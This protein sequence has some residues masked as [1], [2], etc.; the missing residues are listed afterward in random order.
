MTTTIA[1]PRLPLGDPHDCTDAND[2]LTLYQ[3]FYDTLIRRT[4]TGYVPHLAETWSVEPDARTWTFIIRPGVRFHDGSPCDAAVVAAS[5]ERMAREDKGYTLGSPAVWRQYLGGARLHAEGQI[6]TVHLSRPMADLL[7]V[8]VQGFIVAPSAFPRL[9]AGDRTAICGT[10][11]YI[12]ESIGEGEVIARRNPDWFGTPA[13]NATL[14][15]R[16][17]ADPVRR[18]AMVADGRAALANSIPQ[19]LV[20][21]GPPAGVQFKRF[22]IPVC[23]IYLLNAAKGP[24]ADA[25]VRRALSLAIDRTRIIREVVPDAATPLAGFVSPLH[26]GAGRSPVEGPDLATAKALLAEAGHADGLTLAVD[27]PTRLPDEAERLTAILGSEL[28]PLGVRLDVHYHR[29]REAYAHMVRRKEIRDLCV[30]DSSP[31]STFRILYEK[32]DS[33]VAGAWW[34]GYRNPAVERLIDAA[35]TETDDRRR[36][37]ILEE[38]YAELQRDPPWLTLYNPI[39]TIALR[40]AHPGFVMPVDGVIDPATL[41]LL[42]EDG[43]PA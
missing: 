29:D 2:E 34:E 12:C 5:L 1:L 40:G 36:Q 18:L 4:D 31:L 7:D 42:P 17:E 19:P 9:D 3:A 37:H 25:R 38:A 24:L 41:P 21:A 35:R 16:L 10:G 39:R 14:R 13:K 32:I 11:A 23:I 20:N 6:L 33:R 28:A 8:L 30:F 22:T 15:F 43:A 27:C 26:F